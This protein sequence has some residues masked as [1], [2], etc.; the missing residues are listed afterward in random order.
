MGLFHDTCEAI[1]DHAT[2]EALSGP[3]LEEA[4]RLLFVRR[5]DGTLAHLTGAERDAALAARGWRICGNRLSRRARC[6]NKCG[7]PAPRAQVRCAICGKWIPA[8]ARFCPACNN[9]MHPD[10]RPDLAGGVWSREP[11]VFA[12][13]FEMGDVAKVMKDGLQI[14]EGTVAVLLEAGKAVRT[15]EAGRHHAEGG[16]L[17]SVNWFGNP[18]PRTVVMVESGDVVFRLDFPGLR[19]AEEFPVS[20]VAELTMRFRK[21]RADAFLAN[22]MKGARAVTSEEIGDRLCAEALSGVRD[23]CQ[24]SA[25]E[26]LVKDPDRRAQFEDAI[27][28]ALGDLLERSGLELVRVGAVEFLGPQYE[29]MRAKYADLEQ[30]RREV[31]FQKEWLSVVQSGKMLEASKE[32]ELS[33][34]LAQIAQE[35]GLADVERSTEMELARKVASGRLAAKDAELEAERALERHARERDD[36]EHEL[37]LART[38]DDY[39]REKRVLDAQADAQ[40]KSIGVDAEIEETR[41]WEE[42]RRLADENDLR[43]D[44]A[45]AE[46]F[47]G[48]SPLELAMMTEDPTARAALLEQARMQMQRDLTPQQ[49]L[50]LSAGGSAADAA[51]ALA[52]LGQSSS[53]ASARMLEE[54][55]K[56]FE[57]GR[58]RDAKLMEQFASVMSEAARHP[59]TTQIVR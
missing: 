52:A 6:C 41:K 2:G 28:S 47:K 20:A 27:R 57:E 35:K 56:M 32:R 40:V 31:E 18:P 37:G 10:E 58:A 24:R 34:Y 44:Q 55:K 30:K 1:V 16:L 21:D 22:V 3:R 48:R 49:I 17:R 13:R 11:G 43:R 54:Y 59:A 7:A 36:L 53:D 45:R 46:L 42:I 51:K 19:T 25:V 33:D 23:L 26:D 15:L 9:P 50:A 38:R 39:G 14:Q 8:T 29:A 12:Q 4:H 5:P